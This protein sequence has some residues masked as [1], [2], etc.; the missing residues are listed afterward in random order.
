MRNVWII[1]FNSW[2]ENLRSR[3]YMLAVIFGGVTLYVSLLLGLL[4]ADQE[5]RVLLDFGLSFIELMAL[6][7]AAYGAA[8]IILR[9]M[10]TKTIYLILTRPVSRGQYLLGRFIGLLLSILAS[11]LLMAAAHL[12]LLFVKGW[13]W[14]WGYFLALWGSF[15]KV[16]LAAALTTFMALF[17]S[18]A[19]T[20]LCISAILW[21]LGHF[22]PEIRFMIAWG[23]ARAAMVPLTILSYVIPNLQLLN[24][25]DHLG[26]GQQAFFV[27]LAYAAAYAGVW[28]GLACLY[29]RK[30]EF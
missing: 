28:L 26:S 9:E 25:R 22:L 8:T 5:L 4:A 10:E 16:S 20:A 14:Q 23:S 12:S 7:G 3:F 11:M 2:Q 29:L 21:S 1:A 6:A 13:E 18:S 19:L 15:L 27:P 17:S 30:K 24:Y